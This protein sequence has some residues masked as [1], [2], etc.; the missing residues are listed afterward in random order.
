MT[1]SSKCPGS[2]ARCYGVTIFFPLL[3][4]WPNITPNHLMLTGF[5]SL[6]KGQKCQIFNRFYVFCCSELWF[7]F[8]LLSAVCF[9]L[10]Q[11]FKSCKNC[12]NREIFHNFN[13]FSVSQLWLSLIFFIRYS[14]MVAKCL[15]AN[16]G[17]TPAQYTQTFNSIFDFFFLVKTRRY[18]CF[19]DIQRS[20]K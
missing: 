7:D 5:K 16:K 11:T 1:F 19:V 9:T 8:L 13:F 20:E 14:L 12:Q 3:C 15:L 4:L 2:A 6:P 10:L 18:N 17:K